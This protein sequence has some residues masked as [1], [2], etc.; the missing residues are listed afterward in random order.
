MLPHINKVRLHSYKEV[1]DVFK[2]IIFLRPKD[3]NSYLSR[4]HAQILADNTEPALENLDKALHLD[5]NNTKAM[6]H[7]VG[8]K[9]ISINLE[10]YALTSLGRVDEAISLFQRVLENGTEDVTR[11]WA[12]LGSSYLEKGQFTQAITYLERACEKDSSFKPLLTQA[13]MQRDLKEDS[14]E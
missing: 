4:G 14:T 11:I 7:K 13:Q 2:K 8:K 1:D 12:A 9:L 5:P 6:E 10:A 3:A